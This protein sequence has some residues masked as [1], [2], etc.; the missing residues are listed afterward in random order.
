MQSTKND[1]HQSYQASTL[2][3]NLLKTRNGLYNKLNLISFSFIL[4]IEH[5]VAGITAFSIAEKFITTT[6]TPS[7]I[8]KMSDNEILFAS[9]LVAPVVETIIF[10]FAIIELLKSI[11]VNKAIC[12]VISALIF[13]YGHIKN[14]PYS[15]YFAMIGGL[16]LSWGYNQW[17]DRGRFKAIASTTIHH[18]LFNAIAYYYF[19]S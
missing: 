3:N 10:Q 7:F 4:A 11:K 2:I 9:I 5:F 19:S 8:Q 15:F 17:S 13:A 1:K 16:Y 6:G 18:S 14:S 12:G